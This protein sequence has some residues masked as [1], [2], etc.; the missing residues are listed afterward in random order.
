MKNP[1]DYIPQRYRAYV[2]FTFALIYLAFTAWLASNG[3]W[4]LAV[5][6]FFA[7]L[8]FTMAKRHTPARQP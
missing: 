6:Q 8:G 4:V 5:T 3:D 1:L 2:Y 7:G